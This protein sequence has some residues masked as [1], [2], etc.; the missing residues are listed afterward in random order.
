MKHAFYALLVCVIASSFATASEP[1]PRARTNLF[2]E[3]DFTVG[4]GQWRLPGTLT[5]PVAADNRDAPA[6]VLVHGS[7]PE[8]RDETIGANKPFR[9]LAWGLAAKGVAVLRYEKRTRVY[10]AK[11]AAMDPATFTL[12]EEF[13]DDA[14][15]AAAQLRS[16]KGIDPQRIFVL[17]HSLGG[18][19]VSRI[20]Q[21]DTNLA[22][23]ILLGGCLSRPL[24][25]ALASTL[26]YVASLQGTL[27]KDAQAQL[28]LLLAQLAKVKD[29]TDADV[30]SRTLLIGATPRYWLDLREHYP[31]AIA[32]SLKQPLL[33]LHGGRDFQA[34]RADFDAWKEA[35]AS[36]SN[37]TFK[38]Y[39]KLNHLF[40][41]GEGKSTPA[42]YLQPGHMEQAVVDDIA[43]WILAY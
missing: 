13:V 38:V 27:D 20:G 24:E 37:A 10:A 12:K 35:F 31:L 33:V 40:I 5:L 36:R 43:E 17:G 8:D 29:L 39:P 32:K 7:G 9:D 1:P 15:S 2:R 25:D 11:L 28:D 18:V 16:T 23:L 41:A 14:I 22:G 21:A 30:K 42:D 6:L 4:T 3:V 19:A 26:R 34:P